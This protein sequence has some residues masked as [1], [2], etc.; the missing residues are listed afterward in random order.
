[1]APRP[2][3]SAAEI[4]RRLIEPAAI[5]AAV[6]LTRVFQHGTALFASHCE[7]APDVTQRDAHKVGLVPPCERSYWISTSPS[8]RTGVTP[9]AEITLDL[10]NSKSMFVVPFG[11]CTRRQ[12]RLRKRPL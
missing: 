3:E 2:S 11:S 5:P 8:V 12:N 4:G 7:P 10:L 9:L 1:M 6:R